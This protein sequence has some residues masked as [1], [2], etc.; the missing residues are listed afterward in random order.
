MPSLDELKLLVYSNWK[1]ILVFV[2]IVLIG[3]ISLA[4]IFGLE[5][6]DLRVIALAGSQIVDNVELFL[7]KNGAKVSTSILKN[8]VATFEGVPKGA[9]TLRAVVNGEVL[10]QKVD[11]SDSSS[12]PFPEIHA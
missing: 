5:R 8:G 2:V 1:P 11:L 10:E 7:Y 6:T 9:Y 3:V 4:A 12:V